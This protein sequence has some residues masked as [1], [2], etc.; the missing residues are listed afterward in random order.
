MIN[1]L[2]KY[3]KAIKDKQEGERLIHRVN[4]ILKTFE[5]I[6]EHT[7]NDYAFMI[8]QETAKEDIE[9]NITIKKAK[10]CEVNK[11][12]ISINGQHIDM[13]YYE[14]STMLRRALEEYQSPK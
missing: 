2:I 11:A 6:S 7:K 14:F 5:S 10:M 3:L 1:K 4:D 13:P 12:E 9:I 8:L